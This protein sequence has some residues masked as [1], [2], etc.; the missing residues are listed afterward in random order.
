MKKKQPKQA[1]TLI[2]LLTVIA[3]IGILASILIPTVGRVREAARRTVDASNVR[4]IG[5]GALIYANDNR[6]AL[7]PRNLDVAGRVDTANPAGT[8]TTAL[9]F[10]AALAQSGGINDGNIWKS[11][12]DQATG[13][14]F[15]AYRGGT[16]LNANKDNMNTQFSALEALSF[17]VIGG[18]RTSDP[19]T[20]P[21]AFTR[22]LQSTGV[23]NNRPGGVYGS[24]GGHIV[25]I[26][27]N[28]S[29]YKD[30][31]GTGDAG[32]FIDRNATGADN[33][34]EDVLK[35]IGSNQEIYQFPANAGV[36][37]TGGTGS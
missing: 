35:T 36:T 1:F 37:G 5:Q 7:P 23:W 13:A 9:R 10:A 12:S 30:T 2:E 33:R 34:T 15:Q 4:Q 17:A 20:T 18:L 11:S 22:G 32:I 29:F 14:N 27:G 19:S 8:S 25:F 26:G 31:K 28:V 3:I 21:I 16:I 6:E 24:D